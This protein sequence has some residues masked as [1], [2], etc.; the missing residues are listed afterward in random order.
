MLQPATEEAMWLLMKGSLAM[1]RMEEVGLRVDEKYLA[2]IIRSSRER[3]SGLE[4]E[5]RSSPEYRVWTRK[6]GN[7]TSLGSP[8]QL[9]TVVFDCLGHKRNPLVVD[10]KDPNRQINGLPAFEHLDI[11]FVSKWFAWK[12]L[13]KAISTNLV[14]LQKEVVDGYVH[15]FQDLYTAESYRGS[16]SRPN[17]HSAPIRNKDISEMVRTA[18]IPFSVDYVFVESDYSAQEVRVNQCYSG[19]PK[20]RDYILGGGDMHRDMSLDLFLLS[21]EEAGPYKAKSDP[22][23]MPR[24][25]AKNQMVFPQFYGSVYVQCAPHLW[26]SIGRYN[27]RRADGVSLYKHLKERGITEL[28]LC[29]YDQEPKEGTFEWV[30]AR[31][32]RKMWDET[33]RVHNQWKKDRWAQ[34][35]RDGGVNT[36]TGFRMYG[37][38]RRNQI[39]ADPTQGSAFHCLLWALIWIQNEMLRRKWKSR[40]VLQTHDSLLSCVHRSEIGDYVALVQE[41]AVR[42]VMKHWSWITV[43]LQVEYEIAEDNWFAKRSLDTAAMV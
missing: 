13:E 19:D 17:L 4:R 15:P 8:R 33:F 23:A 22:G 30:V 26:D 21:E 28:G 6:F 43:P 39:L 35:Q 3:Y 38:F 31:A 5:L 40:I 34:Y 29:D 37:V 25:V 27:L 24:Y 11:P 16:C 36:L 1:A 42:K 18:I 32:E 41:Y 20:L 10:R 14:G 12:T 2:E 7:K 9:G